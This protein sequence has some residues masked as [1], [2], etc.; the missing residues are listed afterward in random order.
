MKTGIAASPLHLY[1]Q[2]AEEVAQLIEQRILRAGD[3]VPSVRKLMAQKGVSR[4]TAL[5]AFQ[6]LEG[7]G[8]VEARP[9]SGYY[10]KPQRE[11][12]LPEP[13]HSQEPD[14]SDQIELEG[15]AAKVAEVIVSFRHH[16]EYAPFGV[17]TPSPQILPNRALNR[18][19]AAAARNAGDT[20]NNYDFPPGHEELR[21]QIALRAP[22][23]GHH[24][25]LD[26]IV[27]TF[28]CM[29]SLNL[30]LRATCRPGDCVAIESPTYYGL[31]QALE[32]RVNLASGQALNPRLKTLLTK[33]VQ[34]ASA[35]HIS[36]RLEKIQQGRKEEPK[37]T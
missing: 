13:E 3:R 32:S 28:G 20:G 9:Q 16:P 29:E 1:E 5:Q 36:A 23:A 34:T 11:H 7:R 18:V 26:E 17:A 19:L 30:A 6:L 27:T 25:A 22:D 21:R 33:R 35:S 15:T 10:V 24:L 8:L 37:T 12:L 4:S 2:V 14:T 31:L